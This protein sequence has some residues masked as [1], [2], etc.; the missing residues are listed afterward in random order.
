MCVS[1]INF[2]RC[3]LQARSQAAPRARA[4]RPSTRYAYPTWPVSASRAHPTQIAL[5]IRVSSPSTS[6]KLRVQCDLQTQRDSFLLHARFPVP[7]SSPLLYQDAPNSR[8][9]LPYWRSLRGSSTSME[10]AG[11]PPRIC[12]VLIQDG[13]NFPKP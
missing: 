6:H 13:P 8:C 2:G 9:R 12:P 10:A 5:K 7:T 4:R 1:G 3:A 11:A